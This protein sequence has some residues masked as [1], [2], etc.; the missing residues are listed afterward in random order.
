MTLKRKGKGRGKRCHA[1][2]KLRLCL[3]GMYFRVAS[4][5]LCFD[6]LPKDANKSGRTQTRGSDGGLK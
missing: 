6:G 2:A 4:G 1:S 3:V 5:N